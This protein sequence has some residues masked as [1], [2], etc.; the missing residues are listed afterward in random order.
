MNVK[1]HHYVIRVFEDQI[2]DL[3]NNHVKTEKLCRIRCK[4]YCSLVVFKL[5]TGKIETNVES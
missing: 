1:L 2:S 3:S 4:F 5:L